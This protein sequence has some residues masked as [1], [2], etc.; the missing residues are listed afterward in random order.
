MTKLSTTLL[1]KEQLDLEAQLPVGSGIVRLFNIVEGLELRIDRQLAELENLAGAATN[2]HMH[3]W[4]TS[5]L[6]A[7][8]NVSFSQ[9]P[10]PVL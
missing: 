5:T 1:G 8:V 2:R 3:P 10:I 9:T 4:A 7:G 6:N